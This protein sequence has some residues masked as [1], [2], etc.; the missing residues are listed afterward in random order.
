MAD[1]LFTCNRLQ[2]RAQPSAATTVT[3]GKWIHVTVKS[4]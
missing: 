3:V 4:G 2:Q 1:A